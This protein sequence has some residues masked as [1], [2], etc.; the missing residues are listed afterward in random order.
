MSGRELAGLLTAEIQ[1]ST[2]LMQQTQQTIGA[3]G[4]PGAL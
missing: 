2:I 3:F 1:L 4:I